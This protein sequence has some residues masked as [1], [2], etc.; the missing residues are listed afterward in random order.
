LLIRAQAKLQ[1][2]NARLV[3]LQEGE[4]CI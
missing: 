3:Q 4:E 2:D 1:E